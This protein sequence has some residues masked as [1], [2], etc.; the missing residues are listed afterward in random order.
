MLGQIAVNTNIKG[1]VQVTKFLPKYGLFQ[2]VFEKAYLLIYK[3]NH[4]DINFF[5]DFKN[6]YFQE[7]QQANASKYPKYTA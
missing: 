4:L 1:F 6:I 7:Q 2:S 3:F 5:W